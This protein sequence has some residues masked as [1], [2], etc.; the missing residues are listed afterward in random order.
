MNALRRERARGP[1][2]GLYLARLI[3]KHSAIRFP[4]LQST[5]SFPLFHHTASSCVNQAGSGLEGVEQALDTARCMRRPTLVHAG[6]RKNRFLPAH[7]CRSSDRR[8]RNHFNANVCLTCR[9]FAPALGRATED[10]AQRRLWRPTPRF[11]ASKQRPNPVC[12][13]D[14]DDTSQ[15]DVPKELLPTCWSTFSKSSAMSTGFLSYEAYT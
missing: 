15:A 1:G 4:G 5:W 14:G 11:A 10:V 8:A 3:L 7:A 6:S 9:S 2:S 12:N 13:T